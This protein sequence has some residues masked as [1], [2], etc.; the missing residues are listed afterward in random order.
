MGIAYRAPV[1]L[2]KG[3]SRIHG[4]AHNKSLYIEHFCSTFYHLTYQSISPAAVDEYL[5]LLH[6][7]WRQKTDPAQSDRLLVNVRKLKTRFYICVGI[8]IHKRAL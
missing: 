1:E 4:L 6:G 8:R 3:V 5:P 2:S 7:C